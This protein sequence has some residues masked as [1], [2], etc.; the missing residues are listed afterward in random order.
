MPG[1]TV[2]WGLHSIQLKGIVVSRM[3]SEKTPPEEA[4]ETVPQFSS[5]AFWVTLAVLLV[6]AAYLGFLVLRP[7]AEPLLVGA[8]MAVLF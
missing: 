4:E 6:G 3:T 8:V 5:R 1:S 2:A 7:F